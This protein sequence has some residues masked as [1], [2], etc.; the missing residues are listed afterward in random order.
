LNATTKAAQ[1]LTLD[2]HQLNSYNQLLNST[3]ALKSLTHLGGGMILLIGGEKGGVGKSTIATNLAVYLAKKNIDCVLVDTDTQPTSGRFVE[4]RVENGNLPNINC[5]QRTGDVAATLRDLADRYQVVIVD[6]GGRDSKELRTA[7][8]VADLML[9]PLRA[10]QADLETLP[11]IYD[12][13]SMAQSFNAK[14]T[15]F[16][17][18]SM[19]ST[20][21]RV[22]EVNEARDLLANFDLLQ[23]ADTIICDRKA[24]RDALL[25]GKGVVEMDNP[26]AREEIQALAKEFFELSI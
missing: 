26:G 13:V 19:A 20:N 25:T 22:K 10:S 24:Y 16:A 8:I 21:P 6:A 7:A 5:I 23:L 14:L 1:G 3:Q 9:I 18:L 2:F 11:K 12:I 4:R 17:V 15:A